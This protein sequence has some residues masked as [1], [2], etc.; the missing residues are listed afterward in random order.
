MTI[1][2]TPGKSLQ[3]LDI[4]FC[5]AVILFLDPLIDVRWDDA[6]VDEIILTL[7]GPPGDDRF[8]PGWAD[9]GQRLQLG[10]AGTVDVEERRRRSRR[11]GRWRHRLR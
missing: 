2:A 7:V 4:Y 9:P 10:L 5:L 3:A 1:Q 11:L 8:G 6:F